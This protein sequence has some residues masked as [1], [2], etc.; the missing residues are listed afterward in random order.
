MTELSKGS[1]VAPVLFNIFVND[2]DDGTRVQSL[3]MTQNW[4]SG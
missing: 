2:L 4:E 1:V 3:M